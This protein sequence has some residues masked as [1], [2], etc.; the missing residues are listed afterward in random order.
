[1][2]PVSGRNAVRRP[3]RSP[4]IA[5]ALLSTNVSLF[6]LLRLPICLT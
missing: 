6:L 4:I 3:Q 5:A 1:M 2:D